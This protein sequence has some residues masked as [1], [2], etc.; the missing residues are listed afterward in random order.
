VV[1][2]TWSNDPKSFAGGNI[3]TDRT[4]YARRVKGYDPGRKRY[5]GASRWQLGVKLTISPRKKYIC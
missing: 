4:S 3:A 5:D 1:W 2:L